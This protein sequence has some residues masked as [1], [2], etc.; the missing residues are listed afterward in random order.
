MSRFRSSS[1]DASYSSPAIFQVQIAEINIIHVF[2]CSS[3]YSSA[4]TIYI[5]MDIMDM[6]SQVFVKCIN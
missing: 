1:T 2:R 4:D 3:S 5:F 6:L